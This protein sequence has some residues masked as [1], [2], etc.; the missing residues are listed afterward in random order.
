MGINQIILELIAVNDIQV[1]A[2]E[3]VVNCT[4]CMLPIRMTKTNTEAKQHAESKHST[5]T[6]ATCFPG[7]FDPTVIVA[8]TTAPSTTSSSSAAPVVKKVAKKADDLSF[9]DAALLPNGKKK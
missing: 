4:Q 8:V 5:C 6:F 2:A 9:L 1:K 3:V 7:Q